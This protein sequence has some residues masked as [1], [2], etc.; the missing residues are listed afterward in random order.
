MGADVSVKVFGDKAQANSEI[1]KYS[2]SPGTQ[3]LMGVQSARM[4]TWIN[5]ANGT[6]SAAAFDP[7]DQEVWLFVVAQSTFGT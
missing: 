7:G 6:P 2:V 5:K 3:V 1:A 4:V